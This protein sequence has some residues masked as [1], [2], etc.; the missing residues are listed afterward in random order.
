M[1]VSNIHLILCWLLNLLNMGYFQQYQ[2]DKLVFPINSLN[3]SKNESKYGSSYYAVS[4]R[5][6]LCEHLP[7]IR[8]FQFLSNSE[9]NIFGRIFLDCIINASI[10]VV[11]DS[12]LVFSNKLWYSLISLH[13]Y[14]RLTYCI[15]DWER[16]FRSFDPIRS[17]TLRWRKWKRY[18]EARWRR[19]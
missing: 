8:T 15:R 14:H 19:R 18:M 3:L 6:F 5:F 17:Q 1:K 7:P 13:F 2:Y 10:N 4:K 16:S 12:V 9:K 11:S